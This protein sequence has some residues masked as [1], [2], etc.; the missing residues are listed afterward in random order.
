MWLVSGCLL[1]V[2]CRLLLID[3]G[4]LLVALLFMFVF[5]CLP[6]AVHYLWFV[7]CRLRGVPPGSPGTALRWLTWTMPSLSNI[8]LERGRSGIVTHDPMDVCG[9][10]S[11]PTLHGGGSF[12]SPIPW[13]QQTTPLFGNTCSVLQVFPGKAL[14]P[15]GRQASSLETLVSHRAFP[16]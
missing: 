3:C 9:I 7:V 11:V 5:C 2:V 12:G 14:I 15:S 10:R 16:F 4:L 1:F 6:L 8:T 13:A